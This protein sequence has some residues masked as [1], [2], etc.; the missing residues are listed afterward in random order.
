MKYLLLMV[1]LLFT[2][3]CTHR[4]GQLA[5]VSAKEV[6]FSKEYIKG[7]EKIIGEDI[8][9]QYFI[10]PSSLTSKASPE[11]DVA[12]NN[13]LEKY[14]AD[15]LTK[16]NISTEL[17]FIPY[18]YSERKFVVEGYPWYEKGTDLKN[19]QV[20]QTYSKK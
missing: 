4:Y 3:G 15:Y 2:S 16:A 18:I 8:V 13:A 12:I 1:T 14:C 6:D 9:E 10:I 20:N 17:F 19:C 11:I 5:T 7:E